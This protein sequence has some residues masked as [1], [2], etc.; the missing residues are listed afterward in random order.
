MENPF[1]IFVPLIF[2]TRG[3]KKA[4]KNFIPLTIFRKIFIPLTIFRKNF[5][6]LTIFRK[7]FIPLKFSGK[8]FRPLKKPSDRVS[9]LKNDPPLRAREYKSKIVFL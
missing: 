4:L 9:G 1:E 5:I 2:L 7:I 3:N 8:N 6:P